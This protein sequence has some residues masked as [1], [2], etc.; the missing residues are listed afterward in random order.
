[1]SRPQ[2]EVKTR[3]RPI[4]NRPDIVA[5]VHATSSPTAAYDLVF[6]SFKDVDT[7]KAAR[8]LGVLRRDY[9]EAYAELT[10][11]ILRHAT[12]GKAQRG[13]FCEKDNL[14]RGPTASS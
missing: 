1:M 2:E 8:W 7:A 10:Q 6:T 14:R 12:Q 11:D 3:C 13:E 9:P 5:V 4:I